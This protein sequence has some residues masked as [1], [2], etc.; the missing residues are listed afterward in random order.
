MRFYCDVHRKKDDS[1][2]RIT[3]TMDGETLDTLILQ[4]RFRRALE[5]SYSWM[6]YQ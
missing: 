2:Y 6:L 3:Y 1:G 4:R 5:T